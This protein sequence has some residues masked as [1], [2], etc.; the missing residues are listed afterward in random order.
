MFLHTD[1]LALQIHV[2][3]MAARLRVAPERSAPHRAC[4]AT[5]LN[6]AD[7]PVR[8][9]EVPTLELHK[10]E[11]RSWERVFSVMHY[12]QAG[13]L[14]ARKDYLV[15]LHVRD[16]AGI[17]SQ[18]P[19]GEPSNEE[20]R[21]AK[22]RFQDYLNAFFDDGGFPALLNG[23]G[24]SA[25]LDRAL[26]SE[27][28]GRTAAAV[29]LVLLTFAKSPNPRR[30]KSATVRRAVDL[31]ERSWK[32][33]PQLLGDKRYPTGQS[34]IRAAWSRYNS[35]AHL[36]A[37]NRRAEGHIQRPVYRGIPVAQFLSL[38]EEIAH[39]STELG[40][41]GWRPDEAWRTPPGLKLPQINVPA[42]ELNNAK[43]LRQL[44]DYKRRS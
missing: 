24:P 3:S 15:A 22:Q 34:S 12:P 4:R 19:A 25:V 27:I 29:L 9:C 43:F 31:I 5:S 17:D 33:K 18:T 6:H 41:S 16:L 13:D 28:G 14:E 8:R 35:V 21:I 30:Q 36:W 7:T 44:K 23:P 39:E 26:M 32:E 40:I 11:D 38:A 42:L 37:A 1:S 10:N 20:E 2:K